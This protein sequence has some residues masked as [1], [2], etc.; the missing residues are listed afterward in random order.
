MAGNTC[1]VESHGEKTDVHTGRPRLVIR[2]SSYYGAKLSTSV[3]EMIRGW[4]RSDTLLVEEIVDDSGD[5]NF[6]ITVNG[7]L[8]HSRNTQGHG[9]PHE[10]L[11]QQGLLWRAITDLLHTDRAMAGKGA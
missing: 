11:S 4:F 5:W 9:F 3:G 7:V 10:D 1:M 2:T 6:E 8:L